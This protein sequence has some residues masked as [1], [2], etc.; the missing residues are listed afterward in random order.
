MLVLITGAWVFLGPANMD[1]GWYM[2]MARN[3]SESSGYI[4]NFVYMFNVTENPSCSASTC[5]RRGA[6]RRLVA[7]V[8]A[9][10]AD[11]VR[12]G[13]LRVLRIL[14]ATLLG[15]AAK[16]RAVPWRC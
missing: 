12:V 4:G 9:A 11:L 7:V 1:D 10:G 3:A 13:H 16:L 5:C 2:Q 15:R 6:A 14:L 8:D